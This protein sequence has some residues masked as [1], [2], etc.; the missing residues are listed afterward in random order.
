MKRLLGTIFASALFAAVAPS[1]QANLIGDTV[2]VELYSSGVLIDTDTVVVG[3]GEEGNFFGN[4]FYDIGANSFTIRSTGNFCGFFNC[5]TGSVSI[6][7]VSLDLGAAITSV[8][9]S[10]S[11]TDVLV[12]NSATQ[13]TFTWNEQG[14][15]TG[16]YLSSTF[17]TDGSIPVPEPMSLALFGAG[18]LGLG[19]VK[20]RRKCA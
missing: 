17:N 20:Q 16:T 18:L 11:L 15:Q 2:N 19:L 8:T 4:Q 5:S 9:L 10:T 6:Q 1:V 7:L 14:I 3:P 12:G 13:V